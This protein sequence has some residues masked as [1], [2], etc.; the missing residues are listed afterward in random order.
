[1]HFIKG[2]YCIIIIIII[3]IINNNTIATIDQRMASTYLRL[4]EISSNNAN[5]NCQ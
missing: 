2:K 5:D 3:I 4:T 1:M